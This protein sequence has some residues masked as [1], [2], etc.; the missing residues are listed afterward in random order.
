MQKRI[1]QIQIQPHR[2]EWRVPSL[3]QTC[4]DHFHRQ[5]KKKKNN[6]N[7]TNTKYELHKFKSR[8]T[9]LNGVPSLGQTLNVKVAMITFIVKMKYKIHK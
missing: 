8:H 5:D 2:L 6:D 9:N 1:T 7:Y 4:H 3:G